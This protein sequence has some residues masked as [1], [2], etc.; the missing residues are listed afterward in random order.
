M[1]NLMP[2]YQPPQQQYQPPQPQPGQY[3]QMPADQQAEE[4]KDKVFAF[5]SYLSILFLLPMFLRPQ[6]KLCQYHAR[7][8]MGLFVAWFMLVALRWFIIRIS[9]AL[10]NI[11]YPLDLVVYVIFMIIGLVHVAQGQN[12]PLPLIGKS[13]EKLFE[14]NTA[15][16]KYQPP[17]NP[18]QQTPPPQQPPQR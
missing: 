15:Y 16:Q 10:A 11:L 18:P 4:F 7:Q 8:G 6:N 9:P 12:T 3:Q 13:I 14:Q 2:D 17:Q 5:L 1:D